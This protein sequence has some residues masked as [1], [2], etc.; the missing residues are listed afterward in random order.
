MSEAREGAEGGV[1][2]EN[3]GGAFGDRDVG[4]AA[5]MAPGGERGEVTAPLESGIGGKRIAGK[6]RCGRKLRAEVDSE[7]EDSWSEGSD[8][9]EEGGGE[10]NWTDEDIP[11]STK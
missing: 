10:R 8:G 7:E 11:S 1:R 5:A 9:D 4:N 2:A 3:G 6:K